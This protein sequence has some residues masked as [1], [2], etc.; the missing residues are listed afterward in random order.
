MPTHQ[1]LTVSL[2]G[3]IPLLIQPHA[4]KSASASFPNL[5]L[6]LL[7]PL[8]RRQLQV[9]ELPDVS[10]APKAMPL[11]RALFAQASF[12]LG[13]Q[14]FP[15]DEGGLAT[16]VCRLLDRIPTYALLPPLEIGQ[17]R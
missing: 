9:V 11:T 3:R 10:C 5:S 16:T 12:T 4:P 8:H 14:C 13:A 15:L 6:N 1:L 7:R 2:S 17:F